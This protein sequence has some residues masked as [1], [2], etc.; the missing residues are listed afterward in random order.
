MLGFMGERGWL[1]TVRTEKLY[2]KR[3]A[4]R[5]GELPVK[6]AVAAL[7]VF[8]GIAIATYFVLVPTLSDRF[9]F[10]CS[11]PPA[12]L[13]AISENSTESADDAAMEKFAGIS[14]GCQEIEEVTSPGDT[15][16]SILNDNIADEQIAQ[17]VAE[18]VASAIQSNVDRPFDPRSQLKPGKRYSIAV[19]KD[20]HFL[21][22]T[23]ELE[24]S[25]VYHATRQDGVI[26]SWREEVVLE[27][28]TETAC[29]PLRGDVTESMVNAG[30]GIEL[31]LK[32]TTVFR[33]DIDFRSESVRGDVCKILFE[34]RYA[35]D[36]PSGY[37]RILCAVYEGRKTGKKTAILFNNEYYD[38]NG[39]E[40][41]KNFLRSPL[42][43]I[44]VTSRYGS[45]FH[46]VLRVWRKH[47][48]VD[49]GAPQ[50]TPVGSIAN[51]VVTYSGWHNGYG[52]YVC[53]KHENG[54]ESRYGHLHRVFVHKGQ[55][56][57]QRQRIGLVGMT[58]LA[59]GPH[60]DFQL[61]V[62]EKHVNPLG[63]KMV[64]DLRTVP[65]AL[66]NRF[67][68]VAQQRLLSLGGTV[69]SQQTEQAHHQLKLQ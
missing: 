26:R 31:A 37:G 30:E 11:L 52:N 33:W 24:P 27:F 50:G 22:A 32:L 28:K 44:R 55:R 10:S 38:E 13:D 45:R 23:V 4:G 42:S 39:V 68:A 61:L 15:L 58:G 2:I 8:S 36:R 21:K 59:T 56:V 69:L 49:Y 34:R 25:Q 64:K 1:R 16:F 5:K 48:G 12:T 18:S 60:L 63:V 67:D 20:G 62:G 14:N 65:A 54:Y 47:D 57:K 41:K 7:L 40:L 53:V 9:P 19:D 66:K 6:L 43:V 3:N 46:P 35:D 51:G 17:K 29:F